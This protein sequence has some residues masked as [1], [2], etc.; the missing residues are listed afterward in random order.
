MILVSDAAAD[1]KVKEKDGLTIYIPALEKLANLHGKSYA[2]VTLSARNLLMR[3]QR[4]S[5]EERRTYLAKV[6]LQ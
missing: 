1:G 3:Y 4:A 6:S 5:P 2:E